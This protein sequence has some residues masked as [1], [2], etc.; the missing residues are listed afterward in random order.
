MDKPPTVIARTHLTSNDY[1]TVRVAAAADGESVA[2]WIRRRILL[3][4]IGSGKGA[5]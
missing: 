3:G 4:L 5:G 1:E 2:A